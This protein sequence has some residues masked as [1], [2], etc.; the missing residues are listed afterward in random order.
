MIRD[1]HKKTSAIIILISLA[2]IIFGCLVVIGWQLNIQILLHQRQLTVIT[3]NTALCFMAM[4]ISIFCTYYSFKKTQIVISILVILFVCVILS[5]FVFNTNLHIDRLFYSQPGKIDNTTYPGRMAVNT[6]IA[7]IAAALA[8]MLIVFPARRW[9]QIVI[10]ALILVVFFLGILG[11]LGSVLKLYLLYSWYDPFRMALYTSIAMTA[12]GISEWYLWSQTPGYRDYFAGRDLQKITFI[13]TTI[14]ISVSLIVGLLGFSTLM[15]QYEERLQASLEQQ[16]RSRVAWMLQAIQQP[17]EELNAIVTNSLFQK[18]DAKH[19]SNKTD[20]NAFIKLAR[21]EGFAAV[22]V[23]DKNGKTFLSSGEFIK[24]PQM[25]VNINLAH[26]AELMWNNNWLLQMSEKTQAGNTILVQWP[27][28]IMNKIF[29]DH[30]HWGKTGELVLCQAINQDK[31]SCFPTRSN[32]QAFILPLKIQGKTLPM[33]YALNNQTGTTISIDYRGENVIASYAPVGNLGLGVVSKIK[34]AEAYAQ[35]RSQLEA[36]LPIVLIS[37]GLGSILLNRQVTPLIKKI[38]NSEKKALLRKEQLQENINKRKKY[39]RE[40]LILTENLKAILNGSHH[41]IISTDVHGKIVQ[42]N[43]AAERMLGYSAEEMINKETPEIIHDAEEVKTHAEILSKKLN[44]PVTPGFKTFI[45]NLSEE[46]VDENEWT[47]IRKDGSRFPVCVS[48][49][50][51]H[52]P[53]NEVIG[54]MGIGQ[55]ITE[56][57]KVEKMKNEFIS[58]VSHELRTPLTSIQGSLSLLVGGTGGELNPKVMQLLKIAKQNS[59]RLIRLINDML[60]IEKIESGKMEFHFKPVN[61]NNLVQETVTANQAYAEKFGVKIQFQTINS[62]PV[63]T[64]DPDRLIQVLTNLISNAIKFSPQN[65][66]V[67]VTVSEDNNSVRV[68]I[69]DYGNGIPLEFQQRIFQKFAQADASA[70]RE[71]GGTGLGLNISKAIIE[72]MGGTIQFE[73]KENVGTS[74]Y[75]DL[76]LK[77]EK[78]AAH[79][80]AIAM[81]EIL[82]C[83]SNSKKLEPLKCLLE[84]ND[85]KTVFAYTAAEAKQILLTKNIDAMVIDLILKD[86]DAINFIQEIRS[87]PKLANLPIVIM[88]GKPDDDKINYNGNAFNVIDWI[89]G[90]FNPDRLLQAIQ[91][92]KKHIPDYTPSVLHIEDDAD[93]SHVVATLLNGLVKIENVSTLSAAKEKLAHKIYDLI[94]L[95][96]ALPDGDGAE[97]L[98]N[99]GRKHIPVVVF[100]AYDLPGDYSNFVFKAMMKSKTSNE[101]LLQTIK[102]AMR[103]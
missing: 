16:L 79:T 77:Q 86:K 9:T 66:K 97:L 36:M 61:L 63:V 70:T 21:V 27:L 40:L 102:A 98:P 94:I 15:Q 39:E 41:S 48:V 8:F 59:E 53:N 30:V 17:V 14:L 47:Y 11:L 51:L 22:E 6:G 42:F 93:L 32:P 56:R 96:L 71:R 54:Y 81:P 7:F 82:V 60:D 4:G 33:K 57:K 92:I 88:S 20:Y 99:L 74:F 38:I 26:A 44:K 50:T 85:C 78:Q 5:Q 12:V 72:K 68:T 87:L 1:H 90:P 55:D 103:T 34:T 101:E 2:F 84:Q 58:V 91:S 49:T 46:E 13:N 10:Q 64:V 28:M 35:T 83:V 62:N 95:D 23:K 73:T 67:D 100:S 52:G 3:I 65:G 25:A 80:N 45:A 37:L 29:S 31:A 89:N 75:F 43:R 76:P 24:N 19:T 69:K 18:I